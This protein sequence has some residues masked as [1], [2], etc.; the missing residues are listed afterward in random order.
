MVIKGT[1][2]R[3]ANIE[4]WKFGGT[5]VDTED[6]RAAIAARVATTD[7]CP[8]IVVSAAAG[9]T[10]A[11]LTE[12]EFGA[13]RWEASCK[14]MLVA[15]GERL[16]AARVA[17]AIGYRSIAIDAAQI[18]LGRGPL[19]ESFSHRVRTDLLLTPLRRGLV[20]VLGGYHAGDD[21]GRVRL[22]GRGGSDY[23]AVVLG[24]ELGCH[25]RLFKADVDGVYDRC[26]RTDPSAC[27]FDRLSYDDAVAIA[28]HGGSVIHAAAA[29]LARQRRVALHVCHAFSDRPGTVIG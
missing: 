6:K 25:V 7:T 14:A 24:A 8:V 3:P 12:T 1:T 13:T 28:E 2:W 17:A 19:L 9:D 4:V 22:F 10:D 29:R 26:P 27:R 18:I 23:T 5:S 16:S 15:T 20:P 21:C 11:L